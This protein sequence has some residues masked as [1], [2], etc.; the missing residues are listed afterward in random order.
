[1]EVVMEEEGEED[2]RVTTSME[3]SSCEVDASMWVHIFLC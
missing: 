2:R 3:V 1:M